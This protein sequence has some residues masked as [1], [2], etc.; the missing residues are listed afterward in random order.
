MTLRLTTGQK[1]K[2]DLVKADILNTYFAIVFTFEYVEDMPS[3]EI[4]HY[5][6]SLSDL[7]ITTELAKKKLIK[8]YLI[9]TPGSYQIHPRV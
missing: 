7:N 5:G 1:L 6:P 2:C 8:E 3:L 9:K 4:K